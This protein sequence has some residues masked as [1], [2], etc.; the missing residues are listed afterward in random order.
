[1]TTSGTDQ[2]PILRIAVTITL[3][4]GHEGLIEFLN[5][6]QV[7]V[8]MGDVLRSEIKSHL[9]SLPYVASTTVTVLP[10]TS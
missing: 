6:S 2:A 1:M 5:K 10:E 7:I 4:P 8:S 9:E 3:A